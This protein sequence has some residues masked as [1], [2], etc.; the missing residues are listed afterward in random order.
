M[1]ARL[2][3]CAAASLLWR[4]LRTYLESCAN[5]V[6][7]VV[8]CPPYRPPSCW[9]PLRDVRSRNPSK[10][11]LHDAVGTALLHKHHPIIRVGAGLIQFVYRS[12]LRLATE[13]TRDRSAFSPFF[14]R[15]LLLTDLNLA[16][17]S[18]GLV[19][20]GLSV[21]FLDLVLCPLSCSFLFGPGISKGGEGYLAENGNLC[22]DCFYY[23]SE[24][25][26]LSRCSLL[27][28]PK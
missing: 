7:A 28:S 18:L 9:N 20:V 27:F 16:S 25:L 5:I 14:P 10:S 15:V 24:S 23:C 19:H 22:E 6:Q 8:Y 1:Y 17:Y 11:T 26:E 12:H 4:L 3:N 2:F 21:L 13:A